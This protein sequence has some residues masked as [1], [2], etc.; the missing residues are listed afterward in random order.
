MGQIV[1]PVQ[2]IPDP[3]YQRKARELQVVAASTAGFGD[4]PSPEVLPAPP[5][6]PKYGL[7]IGWAAVILLTGGIFYAT[8]QQEGGTPVRPNRRRRSSRR[9]RRRSRRT[10]R[11]RAARRTS[12]NP[13]IVGPV[14]A[15]AAA[16]PRRK[17][18][19]KEIKALA[20][21]KMAG[22]T[23]D[24]KEL[25]RLLRKKY[26]APYA[27]GMEVHARQEM[28]RLKHPRRNPRRTSKRRSSAKSRVGYALATLRREGV[29]PQRAGL[30]ARIAA[31]L[32]RRGQGLYRVGKGKV[33]KYKSST[34]LQGAMTST[35]IA[36][37]RSGETHWLVKVYKSGRPKTVVVRKINPQG[38][39]VYRVE[40]VA[41]RARARRRR[42]G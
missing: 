24:Y 6:P 41:Q 39:T 1:P 28:M 5:A 34:T 13:K 12:R 25:V 16:N 42:V 27:S 33:T 35:R 18:V 22:R 17:Q 29:S 15:Y 4:E 40:E 7:M 11:R 32:A 38:K 30:N 19:D 10:S 21:L 36:A 31:S 14:R 8:V 2:P 26:G 37:S 9:R 23:A 3:W 20:G